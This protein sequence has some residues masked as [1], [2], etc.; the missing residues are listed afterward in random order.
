MEIVREKS[1]AG[2]GKRDEKECNKRQQSMKTNE[3]QP[4]RAEARRRNGVQCSQPCGNSAGLLPRSVPL[5]NLGLRPPQQGSS[6][7]SPKPQAV[8]DLHRH[9]R[10]HILEGRLERLGRRAD[11]LAG[12]REGDF[13][14]VELL[15]VVALAQLIRHSGS[16]HGRKNCQR[17]LAARRAR[18]GFKSLRQQTLL[19]GEGRALIICRQALRTR[20]RPAISSYIW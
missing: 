9:R 16:L 4:P 14:V 10:P 15:G 2:Q 13:V 17:K 3:I 6:S 18:I 12:E 11:E 5:A 19:T 7:P 20:W 8:S 1:G